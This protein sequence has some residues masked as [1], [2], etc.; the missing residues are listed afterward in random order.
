M[1]KLFTNK[2]SQADEACKRGDFEKAISMYTDCIGNDAM[3]PVLYSNRSAALVKN[4]N[5]EAALQDGFK[6][7]Q[8]QPTWPKVCSLYCYPRFQVN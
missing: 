5:Y 6:A 1:K 3:N 7:T 8:L 4:K 2:A